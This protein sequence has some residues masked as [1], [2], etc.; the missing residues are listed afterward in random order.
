MGFHYLPQSSSSSGRE[1]M[2]KL[3]K[4][5]QITSIN[6]KNV[7]ELVHAPS[8]WIL[9][10]KFGKMW[11]EGDK[12]ISS[13]TF[14]SRPKIWDLAWGAESYS[15]GSKSKLQHQDYTLIPALIPLAEANPKTLSI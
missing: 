13:R 2:T 12:G 1:A 11:F 14:W 4:S 7:R 10:G 8:P 9:K 5:Q 6:A 3:L 15:L